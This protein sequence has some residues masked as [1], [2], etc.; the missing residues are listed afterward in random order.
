MFPLLLSC[1]ESHSYIYMQKAD[2][3]NMDHLNAL[4]Q[5]ITVY[6]EAICPAKK[7]V[8]CSVTWAAGINNT[9]AQII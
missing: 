5:V 9:L 7:A 4:I 6:M 8:Q 1:F 2:P 3:A